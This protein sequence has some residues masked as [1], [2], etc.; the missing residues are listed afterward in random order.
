VVTEQDE[1]LVEVADVRVARVAVWLEA[2][3]ED[4]SG[5]VEGAG[6]DAIAFAVAVGT[7]VDQQCACLDGCK[8]VGWFVASDPCS[9]CVE[10]LV[11]RLSVG[12]CH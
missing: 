11:E 5:N 9:G 4:R 10:E 2:P 8:C 3:F 6:D 7:K 1:L 12:S